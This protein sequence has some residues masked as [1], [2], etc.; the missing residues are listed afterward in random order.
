M[1]NQK[2]LY[3]IAG[4]IVLLGGYFFSNS[5]T[6][7]KRVAVGSF[8]VELNN[9]DTYDL[10]AGYVTKEIGGQIQTMLAYNGSIP[11]PTIRVAQGSEVTINFKN[12]TDMPALLHSHGV[13]MDNA[14]DGSQTVQKE[15]KPGE[16]FAYTLKFL[17]AGVYWYHPHVKEVYGQ[18]LGLY[19][20][21]IVTPSGSA[22]FPPV[23]REIPLFLS[24]LPVLNGTIALD[25]NKTSHSLMGHYGNV[26]L[27]NGE[28]HYT[29]EAS[30]GEV[31]RLYVINA[32]NARPFNFRIAGVKMK[33]VGADNGAYEKAT[34]VD[35][36][37]LGPSERAIIDVLLSNAG[38]F[39]IRNETPR[40]IYFLGD[41]AVSDE[42]TD[43]S[44]ESEFNTLQ[45]NMA[46]VQSIDPFRSYFDRKFDK[47]VNLTLT[48]GGNMP[49]RQSLDD[50]GMGTM[51]GHMMPDGNMMGGGMMSGSPDGI[52][53]DDTNQTMNQMSNTD[54][55]K[56][57]I[58]D[59]VTKK[60]NMNIDWTFK[61]DYPVKIRI[62]NDQ[63]SMHPMQHPI[64]F[65]GQRF[66]VVDRDGIR[67]TNLVWKDSVLLKSGETVDIILD[68]S[69]QG[70]W[71][72]HCHISEH[73]E[74]GM[75][76]SFD[77]E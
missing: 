41:I 46:V 62:Y 72:A 48:M 45:K 21:F 68:P 73:L 23:N 70:K 6:T 34:F 35:S 47:L 74:A 44:Y 43:V 61:K 59:Q 10:S 32:A 22:Y 19:G 15:M 1:K 18:G 52:E 24:D 4:I 5:L 71:M 77:V 12:N 76:F 27:V 67:Q 39:E 57:K 14:F 31:V 11:G 16:T 17:D 9:G 56:W 54:S 65:H 69:N 20:A 42:K 55:V 49:A 2:I 64:H 36:V 13:R 60:E 40:K 38:K 75:M 25:K 58:V 26:M 66:L 3:T 63:K 37:V 8:I 28:E 30:R 33:L 53:W 29:L 51:G 7:P 50:G